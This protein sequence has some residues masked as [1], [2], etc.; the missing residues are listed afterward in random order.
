ML[1]VSD[2]NATIEF[3]KAAFGVK[4]LWSRDGA[5]AGLSIGGANFFL[6]PRVTTSWHAQPGLSGFHHNKDRALC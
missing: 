3:Y 6:A 2:G 4:L 5:V 1:A